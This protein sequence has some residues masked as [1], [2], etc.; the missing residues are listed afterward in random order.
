MVVVVLQIFVV[1]LVALELAAQVVPPPN[2][3]YVATLQHIAL[4]LRASPH[5]HL[6]CNTS[7]DAQP[8][9]NA[10]SSKIPH[11]F[12]SR[13]LVAHK[14]GHPSSQGSERR[15]EW[16]FHYI[17]DLGRNSTLSLID[18]CY[19]SYYNP[20]QETMRAASAKGNPSWVPWNPMN[21]RLQL[22]AN[23]WLCK[24]HLPHPG[25]TLA[26]GSWLHVC[27]SVPRGTTLLMLPLGF[28]WPVHRVLVL[29]RGFL[30]PLCYHWL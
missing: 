9:P 1:V 19:I 14:G 26:D 10:A 12:F 28:L 18:S 6:I 21:K 2:S 5:T 3:K 23:V 15:R 25:Y 13:P 20:F 17:K 22:I 11:R 27:P 4:R 29:P 24:L 30:W 16:I 8:I 7:S